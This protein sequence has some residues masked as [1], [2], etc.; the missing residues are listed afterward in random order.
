M[1]TLAQ[2]ALCLA[3][4]GSTAACFNYESGKSPTSPS[5]AG[6]GS[7]MGNWTSSSLIPT[8]STCADFKWNVTEQTGTSARHVRERPEADRDRP[9]QPDRFD[10]RLERPGR[11]QRTGHFGLQHHLERHRRDRGDLDPCSVLR[12][13]LP[14]EGEWRRN[15]ESSVGGRGSDQ[16]TRGEGTSLVPCP[17]Y[18]PGYFSSSADFAP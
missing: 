12:R 3:V 15:A 8:P 13:Y 17:F 14:G 18:K 2:L 11:R 5:A 7:L 1:K 10:D 4:A 6:S 16:G 9:G